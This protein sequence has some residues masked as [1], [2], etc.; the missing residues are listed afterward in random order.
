MNETNKKTTQDRPEGARVVFRFFSGLVDRLAAIFAAVLRPL[1]AGDERLWRML[2]MWSV[3]IFVMTA[4][5]GAIVWTLIDGRAATEL[6]GFFGRYRD[7]GRVAAENPEPVARRAIDGKPLDA[8]ADEA[9]PFAVSIDNMIDA[10][11]QS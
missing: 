10:R 1:A 11:P 6:S 8:A 9:L 3:I 7:R 5:A 2:A 4:G